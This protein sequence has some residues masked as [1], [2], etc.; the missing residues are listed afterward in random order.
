MGCAPCSSERDLRQ[1]IAGKLGRCRA[2]VRWARIGTLSAW[3]LVAGSA[4][5]AAHPLV[6]AGAVLVAA[7]FSGLLLAHAIAY[8]VRTARPGTAPAADSGL[9]RRGFLGAALGAAL[10]AAVGWRAGPAYAEHEHGHEPPSDP[11][12]ED[13]HCV[14]PDGAFVLRQTSDRTKNDEWEVCVDLTQVTC[15]GSCP[16][17]TCRAEVVC[18]WDRKATKAT[19]AKLRFPKKK[20]K[21]GAEEDECC[22]VATVTKCPATVHAEVEVTVQCFCDGTKVGDPCVKTLTGDLTIECCC[23]PRFDTGIKREGDVDGS[24]IP[25]FDEDTQRAVQFSAPAVPKDAKCAGGCTGGG[26]CKTKVECLWAVSG[27]RN[28][29][30]V[31]DGKDC[32][33]VVVVFD[34]KAGKEK[35]FTVTRT[36]T[37]LCTCGEATTAICLYEST[38]K[39]P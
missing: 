1:Q 20:N 16:E 11:P 33:R 4:A 32:R 39:G 36:V 37:I 35:N 9:D 26:A 3:A 15:V 14:I 31:G 28:S 19:N 38:F 22:V 18:K 7:V 30:I 5:L 2:C 21:K 24:T 23:P 25:D 13:C 17:G 34:K 12:R 6:L 27:E 10:V 8:A 29:S